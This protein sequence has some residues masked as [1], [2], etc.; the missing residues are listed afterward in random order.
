MK[1]MLPIALATIAVVAGTSVAILVLDVGLRGIVSVP[2]RVFYIDVVVDMESGMVSYD[3]GMIEVP[4][5]S[6][7]AKVA[8]LEREGN[9]SIVVNGVLTLESENKAYVIEMPCMVVIGT[10]C[11]RIMA[12]IPGWDAPMP[13][14]EG[15]YEV[16][17]KLT[18][19][20]AS[21]SGRFYAKLYLVHIQNDKS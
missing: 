11:Y 4:D 16:S 21:G 12:I 5:G 15:T 14:E 18:W 8:L 17:L 19:N 13:I 9:F 20:K 10:S 7:I 2:Y 6:V 3:L 1:W